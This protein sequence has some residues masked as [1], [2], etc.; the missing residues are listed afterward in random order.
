MRLVGGSGTL[1]VVVMDLTA[2]RRGL[3]A[4]PALPFDLLRPLLDG[5]DRPTLVA[6]A[7]RSDL[8][9][10]AARRLAT[11][12][13]PMVRIALAGNP[14]G[15]AYAWDL[16]VDDPDVDVR[17]E[18]ADDGSRFGGIPEDFP[19][20]EPAQV[21]LSG[22]PDLRVRR[23]MAFRRDPA[24]RAGRRL[25]AD[26][27][28]EVRCEV[29]RHW[30]RPHTDL[31]Q[32][33]LTDPDP[34]VRRAALF[35]NVPPADLVAGLLADP[36]TRAEAAERV[37]M[38]PGTADELAADSDSEVRL[39]LARNPTLPPQLVLHLADDPDPDVRAEIMLRPDLPTDVRTRVAASV[40]PQD[41]HVAHWLVRA[42][43]D[44]RL[45]HVDSPFVFYR[46]AVAMSKDLPAAAI[47]RLATDEDFSVR[48][49]LAENQPEVPGDLFA[50]VIRPTRHSVW[51]L[52]SHPSIPSDLL[53]AM[54]ASADEN[55]RNVAAISPHLPAPTATELANHPA[56]TTRRSVAGNEALPVPDI[57]G[58]LHDRD[59]AVVTAAASNP[60]F[61]PTHA[62]ELIDG[63]D[64]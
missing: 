32:F 51:T 33:W 56:A 50:T 14:A 9:R 29:A 6:L 12:D 63:A 46:R 38:D 58:L 23:R 10:G 28:A 11:A 5:T 57:I 48:L 64:R 49:L 61:P 62:R 7:G 31:V 24:P 45:A 2:A 39:M 17:A 40:E 27:A 42:A 47:D 8:T 16:L 21:R 55:H 60:R 3:A 35:G 19:L 25:A 41:Y 20:P 43:L 59:R 36:Q 53:V 54:A 34:E 30:R 13:E 18:L 52:S 4:N 22:D 1:L 44:V 37:Q 26:P 15:V